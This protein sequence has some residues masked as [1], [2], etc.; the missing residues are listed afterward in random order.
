MDTQQRIKQILSNLPL[1]P[2]VYLMK[3]SEGKI[4]YIGKASSLKKRVSSYFQKNIKD[5][6]TEILVKRITDLEYI[7]TDS[8]IEALLLESNLIKKH[9]PKFNVRLKD[10]KRYPFI[11]VTL[12]EDYPRIYLTRSVSNKK[13]KYFGP[14]TD[15]G[16]ARKMVS[17]INTI[18]KLRT[19]KK[20]LPLGKGERPC[21]NFQMMKCNGACTGN[22]SSE[23]YSELI[24]NV[25]KFLEGNIGPVIQDMQASMKK[26]SEDFQ[27]ENAARIRDIIF[28]IQRLSESQKIYVSIGKD[29]DYFGVSISGSEALVI[30]FEFRKGVLLGRKISVFEN[31]ELSEAKEIARSFILNYYKDNDIPGKIVTSYSVS[32]REIIE[33]FLTEKASKKIMISGPSSPEDHGIMDMIGKNLDIISADRA[34]T[35]YY[36]NVDEGLNLLMDHLKLERIPEE[37]V[38]FDISNLQ[39]TNAV[40]SMVCFRNGLPDKSS[41]RRFKIRGYDSPNDPA[42]IHEAV[43]RR[44]QHLVNEDLP[45]PDLMVIDGGKTQLSRAMEAAS[46]FDVDIK[47]IS[48]AKRLEEIFFSPVEEP[49]LLSKDSPALKIIQNIRDESH[50]FAITYHRKLRDKQTTGSQLDEIPGIGPKTKKILLE[51]FKSIER[52]KNASREELKEVSG[53]GDEM[54]GVIFGFFKNK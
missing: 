19:C 44:V 40:A 47:I 36:Q 48:I 8:E 53:I 33:N 18:F 9:R 10:D 16:A 4:I 50:R 37:I 30:L 17:M 7:V 22:I 12:S 49:L 34:A 24:K 25:I 38:C 23:E 14:Y 52:I 32:D 21:L 41:Y 35:Q 28:D 27:Y 5:A 11:A 42:M 46:N 26:Y 29:Q 39:G 51:H 3:D 31:T 15:A 20:K 13:N 6:K 43:A 54:V 45:M 1:E 2:G